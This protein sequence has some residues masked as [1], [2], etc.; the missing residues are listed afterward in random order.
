MRNGGVRICIGMW[1]SWSQADRYQADRGPSFSCQIERKNNR[2]R[3]TAAA[4]T[5]RRNYLYILPCMR[6]Q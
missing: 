6:L 4:H 1:R 5:H 3:T 2:S